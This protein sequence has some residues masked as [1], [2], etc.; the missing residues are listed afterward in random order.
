MI[1]YKII[2]SSINY[3]DN[4]FYNYSNND[5]II[6]RLFNKTDKNIIHFTIQFDNNN[7]IN[8]TVK[9]KYIGG[10]LFDDINTYI[11]KNHV[12]TLP[13]IK[14]KKIGEGSEGVIY[15]PPKNNNIISLDI[16]TLLNISN[17]LPDT[18]NPKIKLLRDIIQ[19]YSD[20]DI[21]EL[22]NESYV[23]KNY[24][25][26]NEGILNKKIKNA[27]FVDIKIKFLQKKL[28]KYDFVINLYKITLIKGPQNSARYTQ[29][30]NLQL[31]FDNCGNLFNRTRF[32][33]D[34]ITLY[35]TGSIPPK[36]QIDYNSKI[37]LLFKNL[38]QNVF[39][40]NI[41]TKIVHF[42]LR[43]DNILYDEEKNILKIIDFGNSSNNKD[44]YDNIYKKIY[45]GLK[46]YPFEFIIIFLLKNIQKEISNK[47]I[48]ITKYIINSYINDI[49]IQLFT[50]GNHLEKGIF[51]LYYLYS[52]LYREDI[53]AVFLTINGCIKCNIKELYKFDSITNL[54]TAYLIKMKDIL[55][56]T[57]TYLYNIYINKI[58]N[59]ITNKNYNINDIDILIND[60][61]GEDYYKKIDVFYIGLLMIRYQ[62]FFSEH[63]FNYN[64]IEK[65]FVFDKIE[66]RYTIDELNEKIDISYNQSMYDTLEELQKISS[67]ELPANLSGG[68]LN[69][70]LTRSITQPLLKQSLAH[71]LPLQR[72]ISQ[73]L[74]HSLPRQLRQRS[75]SQSLTYKLPLSVSQ[76]MQTPM[77]PI[78]QPII[79]PIIQPRELKSYNRRKPQINLNNT[80]EQIDAIVKSDNISD[81]D[82]QNLSKLLNDE[83]LLDLQDLQDIDDNNIIKFIENFELNEEDVSEK[84]NIDEKIQQLSAKIIK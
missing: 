71:Q 79:Q 31:I 43:Y 39:N 82:K 68:V 41:L 3:K 36:I 78:M 48:I 18:S 52:H 55:I 56:T 74:I 83:K 72:S 51:N 54:D 65:C 14:S 44:I 49:N 27:I 11:E 2:K 64:I 77:Q 73:S 81:I 17:I 46:L 16:F 4:R 61:L 75:V 25:M 9:R 22:L 66:D 20:N 62:T 42:D 34:Y 53:G 30:Y 59:L 26:V 33:I 76:S 84:D 50:M 5:K 63:L 35:K 28:D 13:V 80:T 70:F 37:I 1:K 19:K 12:H 47:D 40:L 69:R 32:Y 15:L 67:E 7:V 57:S 60:I 24:N 38:I 21:N 6:K 23:G 8:Y 58:L 45:E 29:D 10:K